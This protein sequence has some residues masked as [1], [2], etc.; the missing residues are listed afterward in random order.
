MLPAEDSAFFSERCYLPQVL[1]GQLLQI[2]QN[3]GPSP[4]SPLARFVTE[5]LGLDRLDAIET[6]LSPVTDLRNLRKTTDLYGQIESEKQRLDRLILEH[7]QAR[8]LSQGALTSALGDINTAWKTLGFTDV[9]GEGD[10]A[11]VAERLGTATEDAEIGTLVDHQRMLAS[12]VRSAAQ[13]LSA[14]DSMEADF[15]DALRAAAARLAAWTGQ[16]GGALAQLGNRVAKMLPKL[17]APV[18]DAKA[19]FDEA[20][21]QLPEELRQARERSS[22]ASE[23]AKRR[24]ILRAE[25]EVERKNL[26]TLDAEIGLISENAGSLAEIL[27]EL[28]AFLATDGCPVCDRDFGELKRGSLVDH[29]HTK[30]GTLSGSAERLLSLG[31]NRMLQREHVARLQREEAEISARALSPQAIADLVRRAIELEA[32]M[33]ELVRLTDPITAWVDF[34]AGETTARR[35][36]REHQTRSLL[37]KSSIAS[38]G[39]IAVALGMPPADPL[40]S[41]SSVMA[42]LGQAID[43]RLLALKQRSDARRLINDALLQASMQLARCRE[44]DGRIADDRA[45]ERLHDTALKRAAKVR[46]DG[47]A[48]KGAVEAVRA[49]IIGREFNERLNKLWRDLFIRLAPNEPFVPAFKVPTEAT[50]PL[51]PTLITLHRSGGA[52]GTP[53]AM[54]SAGNLNTAALTL[55]IALHLSVSPKLPWLILDDPVQS[56][57]DVHI[58]HFATLLRTLSKEHRRQV[59]VA[60]H[61]RQLFEYLRLELSPAFEE[62]SLL[63]IELTRNATRNTDLLPKRFSYKKEALLRFAA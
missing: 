53:G 47:Q 26:A 9:L 60:V 56:M 41:L 45:R 2:Y 59:V 62:D 21:G 58:A 18:S 11:G 30:V 12:M 49:R 13:D 52:G 10:V 8:S 20:S 57:D 15:A 43:Q 34:A 54:L 24:A 42:D 48:I 37:R 50:R 27:S 22:R 4:D 51:K 63:T 35:A 61:D 16:Y 14:P 33:A 19:W 39:A 55:F 28:T 6:G 3:S 44:A 46:A 36:L 23:D 32:L 38:L 17:V 31:R 5:L 29:V 1:L 40:R 7:Q 25:L